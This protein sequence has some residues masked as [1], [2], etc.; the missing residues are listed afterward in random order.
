M[1]LTDAVRFLYNFSAVARF[2]TAASVVREPNVIVT[3]MRKCRPR[4]C[5]RR[6]HLFSNVEDD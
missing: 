2:C 1:H 6:G 3:I 5:L 4:D